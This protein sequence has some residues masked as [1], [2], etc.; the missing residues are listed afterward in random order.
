L[1][2]LINPASIVI[3]SWLRQSILDGSFAPGALL[4]QEALAKR[5]EVSRVPVREAM[6]RLLA[7]GL[8]VLRPRRGFAVVSLDRAEIAEIFELRMVVEEHALTVATRSRTP[9]DVDA[10]AAILDGMDAMDPHHPNYFTAWSQA[11][12]EFHERL[13]ASARR[14][15]L[16][17]ISRNLR[18]AVEPYI[19]LE[20]HITG[21]F[22][23]AAKE[24]RALLSAFR[25]GHSMEAGWLSRQHCQNTMERLLAGLPFDPSG[26]VQAT[27]ASLRAARQSE[28]E[29]ATED[30]R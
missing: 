25:E 21:Q 2:E 9:D 8:I 26:Q 3:Y 15:R 10:A 17:E 29:M 7:D 6:S 19:L 16:N 12:R 13:I 28:L 23:D 1:G 20:S 11:N 14:Q 22:D 18:D 24:H 30:A 27:T 4:R 5:F